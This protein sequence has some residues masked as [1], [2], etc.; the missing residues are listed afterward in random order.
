[1][2]PIKDERSSCLPTIQDEAKLVP[3]D[4]GKDKAKFFLTRL[5]P[6]GGGDSG[7][8]LSEL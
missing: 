1:M 4:Q 8:I 5:A 7:I 2:P 6:M 3:T